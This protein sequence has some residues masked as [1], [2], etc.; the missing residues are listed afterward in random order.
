MVNAVRLFIP[1]STAKLTVAAAVSALLP[2]DHRILTSAYANG[3]LEDGVLAGDLVVYGRDVDGS[4]FEAALVHRLALTRL[5]R[6][7]DI[8]RMA[9]VRVLQG[10]FTV[11]E[12]YRLAE[13]GILHHDDRVELIHGEVVQ[14]TP[15][16]ARHAG[17]VNY[18][19]QT[20]VELVGHEGVVAVQDPVTLEPR[21][22]PQPDLLVARR[23][24]EFYGQTL[25]PPAD[26]LLLI[27]VADSSV[28]Y[29]RDVKVP[30]YARAGIPEVWLCDLPG[31]GL[32]VYREPT[33]EGY[34]DVRRL[35][36]GDTVTA[37]RLPAVSLAVADV[38]G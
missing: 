15:I 30:L 11:D 31:D 13:R 12:Y 26:V 29:D 24:P 33:A 19:N 9:A 20:L 5:L 1:A 22:Q 34:R 4:S 14:M 35:G 38:L 21:S 27:E 10:P 23:R 7:V 16:G 36:R 8:V 17:R 2:P 25:P 37:L 18:L 32:E 28:D 6:R 3:P